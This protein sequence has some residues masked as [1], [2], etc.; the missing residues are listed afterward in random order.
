MSK[1]PE[2]L[3]EIVETLSNLPDEQRIEIL[4]D[5]AGKLK[6]VP[7]EIAEKPYQENCKVPVCE[8]G[9]YVWVIKNDKGNIS[10]YFAVENPQGLSAKSLCYIL[11]K[12]LSGKQ[13]QE[14]TG[15]SEELLNKI[16]GSGLSIRKFI[17]LSNI[18]SKVQSEVNKLGT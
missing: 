14:I 5:F 17:G 16:Y 12:S 2:K 15:L 1:L 9:V 6:T 18:L 4:I 11:D 13:P 8:S 3:N 7:A 10:L